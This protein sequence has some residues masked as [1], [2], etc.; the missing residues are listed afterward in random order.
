MNVKGMRT[1]CHDASY[2]TSLLR[3]YAFPFEGKAQ[4]HSCLAGQGEALV[5]PSPTPMTRVRHPRDATSCTHHRR[6]IG[7]HSSAPCM[8]VLKA[9]LSCS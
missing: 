9:V 6:S 7:I 5:R 8:N 2:S 3:V 4:Q 1:D